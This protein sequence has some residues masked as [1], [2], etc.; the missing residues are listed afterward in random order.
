MLC[1]SY[2]VQNIA[3]NEKTSKVIRPE[4]LDDSERIFEEDANL[5][6]RQEYVSQLHDL[7]DEII[8]A[9]NAED[10]VTALKLSLKVAKLLMDTSVLYFYPTLF[11]LATDVLDTLGDMVWQ[12]VRQKAEFSEYGSLLH[13]LPEDFKASDI[14]SEAKETCYN[15]FS[16]VGSIR[17]LLPR[18]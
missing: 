3:A 11:V 9:W 5:I 13:S 4:E 2:W 8:R 1:F 6:T 18:M 16:K 7:K 12:R 14:C 10:R 15:W 17:E